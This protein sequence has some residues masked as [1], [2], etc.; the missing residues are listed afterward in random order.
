MPVL[1]EVKAAAPQLQEVT[2]MREKRQLI[3]KSILFGKVVAYECA[4]CGKTFAIS[5]LYGA[6]PA[7]FSQ[8]ANVRDSFSR[9]IC[10]VKMK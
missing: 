8:P 9:H 1:H 10:K 4:T 3:P 2:I 7:N 6:V 5:L